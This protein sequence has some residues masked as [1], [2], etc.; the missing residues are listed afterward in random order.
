MNLGETLLVGG[1]AWVLWRTLGPRSASPRRAP[2]HRAPSRPKTRTSK[3][4]SKG[5]DLADLARRLEGG[6]T[7]SDEVRELMRKKQLRMRNPKAGTPTNL[8]PADRSELAA[9]ERLADEF[10]GGH[11][12][13]I[14][15]DPAERKL[16]RF[17]A[18][19][20]EVPALEYEP[21]EG[22]RAGYT[23]RHESGDRGMGQQASPNRPALAVRPDNKRPVLV[24]MRSPV[25]LD[26]RK[27][28]V[29]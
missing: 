6:E 10:H 22:Q 15:L 16:P 12:A 8:S 28:L 14:E 19:L 11:G 7:T 21:S 13:V 3:P 29:G 1:V 4:K 17:L 5:F 18:V 27:G 23:W 25:K 9:A 26:P 2:S 24:P 20:G